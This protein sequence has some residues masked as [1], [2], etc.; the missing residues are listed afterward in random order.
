MCNGG[1]MRNAAIMGPEPQVEQTGVGTSFCVEALKTR[2]CCT[3]RKCEGAVEHQHEDASDQMQR[4]HDQVEPA[5]TVELDWVR[6][7]R[8]WGLAAGLFGGLGA[9]G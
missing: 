6:N 8:L 4:S 1:K 5:Q 9:L 3:R 2:S 7:H